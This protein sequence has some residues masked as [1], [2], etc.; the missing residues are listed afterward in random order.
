MNIYIKLSE[1]IDDQANQIDRTRPGSL[2][3]CERVGKIPSRPPAS[4]E[5][6]K[7]ASYVAPARLIMSVVVG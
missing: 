4:P 7:K 3:V 2:K 5:R 1:L 6:D